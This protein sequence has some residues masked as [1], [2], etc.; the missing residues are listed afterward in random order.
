MKSKDHKNFDNKRAV[1]YRQAQ[2]VGEPKEWQSSVLISASQFLLD[3]GTD[4]FDVVDWVAGVGD[5]SN[6]VALGNTFNSHNST[7]STTHQIIRSNRE[8]F[9]N[10]ATRLRWPWRQPNHEIQTQSVAPF[11]AIATFGMPT[12]TDIYPWDIF[13]GFRKLE[14]NVALCFWVVVTMAVCSLYVTQTRKNQRAK[15]YF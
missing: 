12:G 8:R 4:W 14:F 10:L 15:K 9:I 2:R 5:I 7:R 6:S 3:D 11:G 13:I 1:D